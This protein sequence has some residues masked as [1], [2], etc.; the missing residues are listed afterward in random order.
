M[1]VLSL[2]HSF[3]LVSLILQQLNSHA[4]SAFPTKLEV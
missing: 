2:K 4:S 1:V 3:I